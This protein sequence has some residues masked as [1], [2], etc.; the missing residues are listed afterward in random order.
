MLDPYTKGRLEMHFNGGRVVEM[1]SH[2]SSY[3]GTIL[4]AEDVELVDV[5]E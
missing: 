4:G 3:G 5:D 2:S 1:I